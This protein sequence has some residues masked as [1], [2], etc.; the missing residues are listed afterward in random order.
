MSRLQFVP[1]STRTQPQSRR[2]FANGFPEAA[3]RTLC[4]W[5]LPQPPRRSTASLD[6]RK[7]WL[8]RERRLP[9]WPTTPS[10]PPCSSTARV[11]ESQ[12]REVDRQRVI[13][14]IQPR[15]FR[16]LVCHEGHESRFTSRTNGRYVVTS[17]TENQNSFGSHERN[18]CLG[19]TLTARQCRSVGARPDVG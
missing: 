8:Q 11:N 16:V 2:I 12:S 9:P 17:T 7:C 14:S 1:E 6:G 13:G 4:S 19:S 15:C 3:H 18:G 5:H 10:T